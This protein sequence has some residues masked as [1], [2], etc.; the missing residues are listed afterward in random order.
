M[1]L[2]GLGTKVTGLYIYSRWGGVG[3]PSRS[4]CFLSLQFNVGIYKTQPNHYSWLTYV[5]TVWLHAQICLY[6]PC[7][8]ITRQL[9]KY[10]LWTITLV[11]MTNKYTIYNNKM[12]G[13]NMYR[14]G[15]S[16]TK[17]NL[18]IIVGSHTCCLFGCMHNLPARAGLTANQW[19]VQWGMT[20]VHCMINNA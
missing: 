11:N 1:T 4:S 15:H 9:H 13:Y 12:E 6:S 5:L 19:H 14:I 18:T 17:H 10:I 3:V 16:P 20:S 8:K 2:M 7:T